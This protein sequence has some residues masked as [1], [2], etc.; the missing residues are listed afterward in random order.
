[1]DRPPL[2]HQRHDIRQSGSRQDNARRTLCYVGRRADHYSDLGLPE[3]RRIVDTVP[4][5]PMTFPA[6][7]SCRTIER[8]SRTRDRLVHPMNK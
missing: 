1:M 6:A 8:P 7:C 3:C 2:L 5:M 4:V